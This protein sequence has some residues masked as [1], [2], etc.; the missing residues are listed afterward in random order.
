MST[1]EQ[2][3]ELLVLGQLLNLIGEVIRLG[4]VKYGGNSL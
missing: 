4:I 3:G 2:G 1:L